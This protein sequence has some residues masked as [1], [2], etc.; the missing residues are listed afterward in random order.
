MWYLLLLYVVRRYKNWKV[1]LRPDA[2]GVPMGQ[3]KVKFQSIT[4]VM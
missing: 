4:T 2:L 1:T 3:M